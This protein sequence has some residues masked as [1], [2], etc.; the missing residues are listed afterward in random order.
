MPAMLPMPTS[1]AGVRCVFIA[2]MKGANVNTVPSTLVL[3]TSAMTGRSSGYSVSVPVDAGAGD[4]DVDAAGMREEAL[5]GAGDGRAVADVGRVA[6]VSFG[7]VQAGA[8]LF[9]RV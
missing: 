6:A 9:E 7:I 2:A 8:Q 1:R 4:D 3:K 5:R